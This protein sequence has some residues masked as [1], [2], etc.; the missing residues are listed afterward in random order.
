MS[1]NWFGFA[2]AALSIVHDTIF[3]EAHKILSTHFETVFMAHDPNIAKTIAKNG[4]RAIKWPQLMEATSIALGIPQLEE[5]FLSLSNR[6]TNEEKENFQDLL[7]LLL[8]KMDDIVIERKWVNEY[9][10]ILMRL[11]LEPPQG[12]MFSSQK[13]AF[14]EKVSRYFVIIYPSLDTLRNLYR[15]CVT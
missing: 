8:H 6:S 1:D 13:V 15:C 14:L 2:I 11:I 7:S 4:L 12:L 5:Y 3:V 9:S 10:I